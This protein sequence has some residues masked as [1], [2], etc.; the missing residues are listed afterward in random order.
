M[1]TFCLEHGYVIRN[2]VQFSVYA[3]QCLIDGY[4]RFFV[5]V[6][7]WSGMGY[8]LMNQILLPRCWSS[9][10]AWL[11]SSFL[12]SAGPKR[13]ALGG[14]V[15]CEHSAYKFQSFAVLYIETE[16]G[17]R[18]YIVRV[19]LDTWSVYRHMHALRELGERT[20]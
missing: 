1:Q 11:Q 19:P 2:S 4:N 14:M 20:G 10:C 13:V 6:P 16:S 7:V 5:E 3:L 12:R 15:C 8:H 18:G 9:S 17:L